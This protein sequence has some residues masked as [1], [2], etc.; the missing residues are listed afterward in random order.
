MALEWAPQVA[1]APS[2]NLRQ[3]SELNP[4]RFAETSPSVELCVLVFILFSLVFATTLPFSFF[5][6]FPLYI[7]VQRLVALSMCVCHGCGCLCLPTPAHLSTTTT[8]LDAGVT[9]T[10]CATS[11]V[12]CAACFMM[13]VSGFI[14]TASRYMR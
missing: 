10:T 7:W 14:K 13:S 4:F 12:I 3:N 1:E 11:S 8:A 6:F 9:Y 5:F 2:P